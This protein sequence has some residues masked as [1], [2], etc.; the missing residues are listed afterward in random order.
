MCDKAQFVANT[1]YKLAQCIPPDYNAQPLQKIIAKSFY[2]A[3]EI[4]N[5]LWD[6]LFKCVSKHYNTGEDYQKEMCEIYN[7]SYR[8]YL[9]IYV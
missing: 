9:R 4:C 1:C 5:G 8:E 2:T 3:P 6:D 7:A